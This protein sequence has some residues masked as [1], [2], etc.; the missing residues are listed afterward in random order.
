M[1]MHAPWI[2]CR[3]GKKGFLLARDEKAYYLIEVGKNL[4]Y[5]TEE[6]LE[7]QGVSEE[8]LKELQLPFTYVPKAALRGVAIGGNHAGDEITLYLKS[9]MRKAVL[10]LD[11]ESDWMEGFFAG[12]SRFTPPA[13]KKA[14]KKTDTDRDSWRREKRDPI[15]YKKLWWVPLA[16]SCASLL[17][18]YGYRQ[19]RHPVWFTLCL[20]M[21]A[22]PVALD[23]FMPSYFTMFFTEKNKE[24]D[25][26]SLEAPLLINVIG[27][28]ICR[29]INW[30]DDSPFWQI[31]AL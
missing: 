4:D 15:L 13:P 12:I 16:L 23:V 3:V 29:R 30:L 10:E 18:L 28:M 25:A 20:V 8:L 14:G 2:T 31:L 21:M 7:Q 22:V 24:R 17:A 19:T 6:W 5:A 27:M 9:E 1:E 26:I 11:Y